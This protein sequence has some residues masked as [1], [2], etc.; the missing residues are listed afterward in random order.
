MIMDISTIYFLW[1]FVFSVVPLLHA[2]CPDGK[3]C[4]V[5]VNCDASSSLCE[6]GVCPPGGNIA[7]LGNL[8]RDCEEG[9]VII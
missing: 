3:Y 2:V 5:D 9:F 4:P 6:P 8:T 7:L 1:L